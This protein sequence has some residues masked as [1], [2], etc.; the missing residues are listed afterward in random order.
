MSELTKKTRPRKGHRA[1][2]TKQLSKVKEIV[3]N[4]NPDDVTALTQLKLTLT[5]KIE[6]IS[7][8]DEQILELT[9]EEDAIEREIEESS[10]IKNEI[11]GGIAAI[12]CTLRQQ[13]KT[14]TS[15]EANDQGSQRARHF[16]LRV[17][18]FE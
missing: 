4:F 7:R 10:E 2:V 3:S 17:R 13:S 12:D 14:L 16:Q 1:Y 8:L 11:H 15:P 9:E 5:E 6:T 18:P